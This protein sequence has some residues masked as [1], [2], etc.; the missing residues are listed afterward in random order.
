MHR[1][2]VQAGPLPQPRKP[3]YAAPSQCRAEW[4]VWSSF[5][6][7]TERR[8]PH[9]L[10]K[11]NL[12]PALIAVICLMQAS[13]VVVILSLLAVDYNCE[14]DWVLH[15]DRACGVRKMP[16]LQRLWAGRASPE[17]TG[18]SCEAR[19]LMVGMSQHCLSRQQHRAVHWQQFSLRRQ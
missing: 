9:L 10:H 5:R 11:I 8:A 4:G 15:G 16:A 13:V 7:G 12:E 19:L 3:I 6:A 1:S 17:S 18:R 2:A 14:S